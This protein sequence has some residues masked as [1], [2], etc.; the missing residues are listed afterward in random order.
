MYSVF[1]F[2]GSLS[3][4]YMREIAR[5]DVTFYIC[6]SVLRFTFLFFPL[7]MVNLERCASITAAES[8]E[9]K[10]E[11]GRIAYVRENA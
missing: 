8:C 4:T 7:E 9:S 10:E 5:R 11:R 3:A 1:S 6:Y 2:F